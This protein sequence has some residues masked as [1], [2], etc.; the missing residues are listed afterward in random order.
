MRL[1]L[2]DLL[3]AWLV[4]LL[5]LVSAG[6]SSH[7]ASPAEAA[8]YTICGSGQFQ[9]VPAGSDGIPGRVHACP[10][11]LVPGLEDSV[12]S[13]LPIAPAIVLATCPPASRAQVSAP[14]VRFRHA[15]RAPPSRIRN[16]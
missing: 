4:L 13:P 11:C 12:Q 2:R 3:S 1:F 15:I 7:I 5:I 16:L 10:D 6:T 14:D 8:G 9:G